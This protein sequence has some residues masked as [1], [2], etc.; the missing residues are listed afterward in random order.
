MAELETE[1]LATGALLI[2]A[3]TL[4]DEGK[5]ELCAALLDEFNSALLELMTTLDAWLALERLSIV[6][7]PPQALSA[8]ARVNRLRE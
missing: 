2:T 6:A 1:E 4:D 7:W 5:D 8:S 3:L